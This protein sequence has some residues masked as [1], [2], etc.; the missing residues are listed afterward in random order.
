MVMSKPEFPFDYRRL[1]GPGLR[2]EIKTGIRTETGHSFSVL[3]D[4]E[5]GCVVVLTVIE[6]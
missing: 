6:D 1:D 4:S 5:E 3:V 2:L